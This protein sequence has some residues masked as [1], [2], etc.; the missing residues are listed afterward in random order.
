[1]L[2]G[3]AIKSRPASSTARPLSTRPATWKVMNKNSGDFTLLT[4]RQPGGSGHLYENRNY[5]WFNTPRHLQ[6]RQI[7]NKLFQSCRRFQSFCNRNICRI[8]ITKCFQTAF[9]VGKCFLQ[10]SFEFSSSCLLNKY[11]F[12]T[13]K[14]KMLGTFNIIMANEMYEYKLHFT[15]R[16]TKPV[17]A[18]HRYLSTLHVITFEKAVDVMIYNIFRKKW[19]F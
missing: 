1:M 8:T 6:P 7:I 18:K 2:V 17:P 9:I 10:Y 11:K 14:G 13:H 19:A 3:L 12:Q 4:K 15:W 5:R 16:W